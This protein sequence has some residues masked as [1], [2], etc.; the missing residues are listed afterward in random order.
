MKLL[1]LSLVIV[2]GLSGNSITIGQTINYTQIIPSSGNSGT[3]EDKLV[4]LAWQ[5]YPANKILKSQFEISEENLKQAKW[6]WLDQFRAQGNLNEFSIDPPNGAN[7]VNLFPRY[8]VSVTISP[9]LAVSIPSKIKQAKQSVEIA[10]SQINAQ[11][12]AV[13]ALVLNL[14][15]DYL[16]QKKL[17]EVDTKNAESSATAYQIIEQRFKKGQ[18]GV[19]DFSDASADNSAKQRVRYSTEAAFYKAKYSIEEVIGVPIESVITQ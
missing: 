10:E 9:Y 12:L 15:Q 2:I 11:K 8:N 4:W 13:R 17:L 16:L 5:N 6:M 3:T 1:T 18:V 7:N 19:E 14:Y